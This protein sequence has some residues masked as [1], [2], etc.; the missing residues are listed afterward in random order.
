MTRLT[1]AALLGAALV[2]PP[3]L[4]RPDAQGFIRDWLVLAPIAVDEEMGSLEIERELINGEAVVRPTA[5][6]KVS[7]LGWE[8]TWTV[9]RAPDFFI[10]FREAFGKDRGEDAAAYAVVYLVAEADMAVK[11]AVGS[12]DEFKAWLNGR[13]VLKFISTRGLEKDS[14][15][16]DVTLVRGENTLVLKVINEKNSWQAC[17]RF[18]KDGA[19]VTNLGVSLTPQQSLSRTP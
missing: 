9:H 6:E 19:G 10:D 18:L 12:N 17:A 3:Q 14:D 7:R 15:M 8:W 1:V 11:L 13:P 2:A 5:G 4:S 16:A